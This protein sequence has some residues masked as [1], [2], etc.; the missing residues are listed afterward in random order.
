MKYQIIL[1]ILLLISINLSVTQA[2]DVKGSQDHT[3]IPRYPQSEIKYYYQKKYNELDFPQGVKGG[4]PTNYVTAKGKHTSI[5]YAG[6]KEISPLEI[7]RNYENALKEAGAKILFSCKGKYAPRGCDDY[8]N[9][10]GL[11]FFN[12]NY[13]KKRHNNTDQYIL[14]NGSDDQAFILGV[15]ESDGVR[16]YVE[17]GIDGNTFNQQAGIQVEVVEEQKMKQK[18]TLSTLEKAMDKEGKIALYGILFETGSATLQSSSSTE[19]ALLAEYL[20]KNK[21]KKIY[22]V[23]HTDNTGNLTQNKQLSEKRATAVKQALTTKFS[24]DTS[25]IITAGVGPLA[26]VST[27]KTDAGR[28]KNR[29]VE[30]ILNEV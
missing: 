28:Q 17:I 4:K 2:Q 29:R 21:T 18:I 12:E 23:G 8:G 3:I 16:T 9:N 10:Y 5:L 25:R 20:K 26:P 30:I 22:I 7:F 27:N 15:F 24:I 19:I 13:Y 1:V 11:L 14:L 6:P